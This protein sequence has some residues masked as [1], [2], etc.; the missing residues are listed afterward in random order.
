[1]R[2]NSTLLQSRAFYPWLIL[3]LAAGF[4][5]AEYFARVAPSVMVPDLM[6]SFKVNALSLGALSAFFYYA[7]VAMQLPVGTLMDRY[8]PRRLLSAMAGICGIACLLFAKTHSLWIAD[9]ARFLMGFSAAFAFVGALKIARTWFS[10][11]R[12]GF[13]AGLTQA[14]GMVGAAVGEGPVA[15]LVSNFGWRHSMEMIGLVLL[16]LAV[17]IC[18]QAYDSPL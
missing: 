5:F 17:L 13:L 9:L 10:P 3:L 18:L 7:Y 2:K 8:G 12:F 1:M 15:V 14:L 4:F 11:K 16:L 6:S